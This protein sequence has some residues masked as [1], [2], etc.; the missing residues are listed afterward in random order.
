MSGFRNSA[1]LKTRE[2]SNFLPEMSNQAEST[3]ESTLR[4]CL[5]SRSSRRKEAQIPLQTR[6]FRKKSEPPYVGCYG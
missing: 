2:D 3:P 5:K 4:A 1:L 6:C